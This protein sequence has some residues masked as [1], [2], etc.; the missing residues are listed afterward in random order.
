MRTTNTNGSKPIR[1]RLYPL[2]KYIIELYNHNH[3]LNPHFPSV[4]LMPGDKS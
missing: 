1:K 3:Y 4:I 2:S